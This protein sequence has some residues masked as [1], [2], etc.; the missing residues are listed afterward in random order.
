MQI[1]LPMLVYYGMLQVCARCGFYAIA[2]FLNAVL[3]YVSGA[4][5]GSVA[6]IGVALMG[7]G[8]GLTC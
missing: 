2:F 7:I 8:S 5:W 6:S 3:S 1:L 4:S